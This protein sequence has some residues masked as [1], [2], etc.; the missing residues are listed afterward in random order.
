MFG[1]TSS[2]S[3]LKIQNSKSVFTVIN[4]NVT[5]STLERFENKNS[6]P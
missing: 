4:M 2:K 1:N 3:N 5:G 6:V